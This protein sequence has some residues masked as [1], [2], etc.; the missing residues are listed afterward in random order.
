[1]L[2]LVGDA[3]KEL[4]RHCCSRQKRRRRFGQLEFLTNSLTKK[5]VSRRFLW[6]NIPAHH[7]RSR[8][9]PGIT[10]V[11]PRPNRDGYARLIANANATSTSLSAQWVSMRHC[12]PLPNGARPTHTPAITSDHDRNLHHTPYRDSLAS[13]RESCPTF[14]VVFDLWKRRG[15]P[16]EFRQV[17]YCG[18]EAR[19]WGLSIVDVGTSLPIARGGF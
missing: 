6:P 9:L 14:E 12:F 7:Q 10:Y 18:E 17:T 1:M 15:M 13:A 5:F 11:I 16:S 4:Q 8:T 3:T 2:A 19:G